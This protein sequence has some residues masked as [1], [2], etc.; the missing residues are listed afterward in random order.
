M[1]KYVNGLVAGM[2][3]KAKIFKDKFENKLKDNSGN[4]IDEAIK[5]IGGVVIGLIVIGALI[6]MFRTKIISGLETKITEIFNIK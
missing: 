4:W 6:V 2:A 5:Y 1:K 3:V